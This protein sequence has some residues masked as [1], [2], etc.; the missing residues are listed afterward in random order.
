LQK[1][2]LGDSNAVKKQHSAL[3]L[4]GDRRFLRSIHY[5]TLLLALQKSRA[6]P[7]I[8]RQ[9]KKVTQR[10]AFRRAVLY[11]DIKAIS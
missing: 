1:T 4:N 6:T 8:F 3:F 2:K 5:K 11:A 7:P 9:N 10:G